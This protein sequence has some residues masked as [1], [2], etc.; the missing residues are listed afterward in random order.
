MISGRDQTVY[1]ALELD[2]LFVVVGRVPFCEAGF[3]SREG[4][5]RRGEGADGEG[6]DGEGRG[7]EGK[8][9]AHCRFWMRMKDR[10]IVRVESAMRWVAG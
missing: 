4:L 3:A 5:V 2:F 6:R 8:G 10:T 9:E 7:G 1:F